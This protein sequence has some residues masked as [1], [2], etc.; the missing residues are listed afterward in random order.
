M[1][2]ELW[3]AKGQLVSGK[4]CPLRS[5]DGEPGHL[6]K[7]LSQEYS[8]ATPISESLIIT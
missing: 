5:N 2:E 1:N 7:H 4:G 3:L 6:F 8:E